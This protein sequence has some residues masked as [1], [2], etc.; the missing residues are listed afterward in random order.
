MPITLYS[1][2]GAPSPWRVQIGLTFK[3]LRYE[4]KTLSATNREHKS[5][6]FLKLSPRGTVP[7]LIDGDVQMTDS[8]AILAWLD[9]AYPDHPLFGENARDAAQIWQR[10]ATLV[11]FLPPAVSAVLRPLF[12]GD[13]TDSLEEAGAQ[14][15][16]EL[17]PLEDALATSAYICG[18]APSAA[19]AICFPHLRLI[20][21]GIETHG[22]TM[23]RLGFST[24]T[25]PFPNLAAWITRIEDHPGIEETFP[26]H[27]QNAA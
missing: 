23:A 11:E 9:R 17:K 1:V 21:R 8:L 2:S 5:E 15:I 6:A 16:R 19:D 26:P 7:V 22:D 3:G 14:L 20:Q 24:L 18:E 4:L 27:W 12:F 10:A 13:K 25:E